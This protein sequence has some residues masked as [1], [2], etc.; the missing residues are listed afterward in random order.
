MIKIPLLYNFDTET[1]VGEIWIFN[2]DMIHML[3]SSNRALN[4]GALIEMG[5]ERNRILTALSIV[6]RP[7]EIKPRSGKIEV[8]EYLTTGQ[9]AQYL[10][11]HIQTIIKWC[12]DGYMKCERT[13]GGNRKI[14]ISE[15]ERLLK[16]SRN[17]HVRNK[18]KDEKTD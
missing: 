14:P 12:D 3:T 15:I 13:R 7:A 6:P 17:Q 11:T 5:E 8:E 4:L 10:H 16:E 18:Y 1:P 9:A 2:E